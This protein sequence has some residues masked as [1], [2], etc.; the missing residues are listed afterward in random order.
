[1]HQLLDGIGCAN[2]MG[3][4]PDLS[5]LYFTDSKAK[6]IYRFDYDRANGALTNQRVV[7]KVPD[8]QGVP[9]GM[10]VDADGRIWSAQWGGRRV[11]CWNPDGTVHDI[12]HIPDAHA[13]SC[14]L[15]A[16]DDY[17]DLYI[18]TAGGEDKAKNGDMAGCLLR[19]AGI[20]Q[21]APENRSRIGL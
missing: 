17:R 12:L 4:T 20:G 9:D 10:T 2:G 11:T 6:T 16:G 8:G 3:H 13:V 21:G 7:V 1:M 5:S 18:T 14:P 15:F 19:I